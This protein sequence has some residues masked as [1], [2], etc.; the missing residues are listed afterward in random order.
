[1]SSE[2]TQPIYLTQSERLESNRI[3]NLN[4]LWALLLKLH[5]TVGIPSIL[6]LITWLVIGSFD[7]REAI[8]LEAVERRALSDRVSNNATEIRARE[9]IYRAAAALTLE[10]DYIKREQAQL[11][12]E[13]QVF[14]SVAEDNGRKMDKLLNQF[15]G[16]K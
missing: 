14:R 11:R 13:L 15:E 5:L 6:A 9:E 4:G 12:S 3:G 1:M 10:I 2:K 7:N 8:R 16:S